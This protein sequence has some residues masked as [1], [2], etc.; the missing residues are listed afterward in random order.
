VRRAG[1]SPARAEA[2]Q[3]GLVARVRSVYTH[4]GLAPPWSH[5]LAAR[6]GAPATDAG[7]ALEILVRRGDVV[8]V[9]P[10]LCFDRSAI[11]ALAARL[12]AHLTAQPEITPQ[13]WKELSGVTRKYAIPLAE[14]FD[15]EKLTLR[16][17]DV[18]RLRQKV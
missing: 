8:R 5:E 16:V 14:H 17:G 15:A 4:G 1:F 10:D 2:A 3:E 9:K 12:R 11:D 6:I 7:A 18:R 13:Q